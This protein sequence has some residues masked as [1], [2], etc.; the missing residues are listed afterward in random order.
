MIRGS[1]T[2]FSALFCLSILGEEA[3]KQIM[4]SVSKGLQCDA[5]DIR[6]HLRVQSDILGSTPVLTVMQCAF[7]L[8]F[9]FPPLCVCEQCGV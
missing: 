5:I 9:F 7:F 4:N 3:P 6:S 2:V 8:C 1:L